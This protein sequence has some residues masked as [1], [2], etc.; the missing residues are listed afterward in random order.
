MR[1]TV[2]FCSGLM[3]LALPGCS[4][5][6]DAGPPAGT[7]ALP[8]NIGNGVGSQYGNYAGQRDSEVVGPSGERCIVFNWD[9]PLSK[10]MVLR[11]RSGS[12]ASR[13]YP[14]R[15]VARELS[16]TVIPMSESTLKDEQVEA[17]Q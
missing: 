9:R 13:E 6:P 14:G 2:V 3:A 5:T 10:D 11:L 16:R 17:P 4:T 15:M 12:C 1:L 8:L 7:S